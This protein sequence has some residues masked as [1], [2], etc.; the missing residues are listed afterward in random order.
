MLNACNSGLG[1]QTFQNEF[2]IKDS[3]W[4]ADKTRA[5]IPREMFSAGWHRWWAATCFAGNKYDITAN[6][7]G[8]AISHKKQIVRL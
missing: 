5:S 1:I 7:R 3:L 6:F 4:R 2:N 8:S